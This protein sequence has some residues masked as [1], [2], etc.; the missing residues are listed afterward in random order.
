MKIHIL[1]YTRRDKE[2][3]SQWTQLEML[4]KS[5]EK[6]G[7]EL[8]L[9]YANECQLKFFKKPEILVNNKKPEIDILLVKAGFLGVESTA[10]VSLIKQFELDGVSVVNKHYAVR[11]S[12]NKVQ[13][14]QVLQKHGVP[15]PK[16]MVV[17]SAEMLEDVIKDV[18]KFPLILKT[19]SGSL[20]VGVA[21]IES[22]RAMQSIVEM[23]HGQRHVSVV[24]Q[25][26]IRESSGKDIRAFVV[27][28]KVVAAMERIA[29]KRGEFRS[30]YSLGG[31]VRKVKLTDKELRLAIKAAKAC[32]LEMAGVDII[33]TKK[34][35]MVLEVNANP[36]IEGITEA[37]GI[38]VAGEIIKYCV[39][40]AKSEKRRLKKLAQ[41]KKAKRANR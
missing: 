11:V 16:T 1:T 27:G 22:K 15:T 8:E 39:K 20:G 32:E 38:D 28:N 21:I 35:P 5:A 29:R 9:I 23:L 13:N 10:H 25:E 33:R 12:K 4:R 6:S 40:K 2:E 14:I 30:N 7:H 26:Y 31:K 41:E 17:R 3:G 19:S 36:G 37:T 34:G 24:I 18:G